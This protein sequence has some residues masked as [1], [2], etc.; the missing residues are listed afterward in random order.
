[1]EKF[2]TRKAITPPGCHQNV[3]K[4]AFEPKQTRV[5]YTGFI[6]FYEHEGAL[7]GLHRKIMLSVIVTGNP[8]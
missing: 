1:V 7:E 6:I 8:T 3:F 5:N 4:S 2:I